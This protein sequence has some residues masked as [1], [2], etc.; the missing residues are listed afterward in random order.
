MK[1][2]KYEHVRIGGNFGVGVGFIDNFQHRDIINS[3]AKNGYIYKGYFPTRI[4]STGVVT[5]MDLIFEI[6][7]D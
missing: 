1:E 2:Y 4:T 3:Y 5:E 7:K 6:D